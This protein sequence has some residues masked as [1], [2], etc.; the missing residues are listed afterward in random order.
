MK[1]TI[2]FM[3]L[4]CQIAMAQSTCDN[5]LAACQVLVDEQDK[6]ILL[7]KSQVSKLEDRLASEHSEPIL[8]TWLIFTFG[9][10]AGASIGFAAHS[11]R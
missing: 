6:S 5:A 2:I 8:P 3:T 4:F 7:L 9:V 10:A 11:L 1:K